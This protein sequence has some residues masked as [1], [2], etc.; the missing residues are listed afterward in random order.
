MSENAYLDQMRSEWRD[1]A[2][3]LAAWILKHLVNRTDVWGRYLPK[4]SRKTNAEKEGGFHGNAITA[5]FRD[6]RGKVFLGVSS[7]EKHFKAVDGGVLGIHSASSDGSSRWFAIDIDL[8]DDDD[9]SV[10]R[11]GNFVAAREWYS[12]LQQLG[13]DPLLFDSKWPRRIPSVGHIC[14]ADEFTKRPGIRRSARPG[15]SAARFGPIARAIPR[16][17]VSR[18]NGFESSGQLAAT[19]RTTSHASSLHPRLQR[20]SV[21]RSNLAG[22]A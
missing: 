12:A 20:S 5:P 3:E 14:A 2:P 6:E 13:L 11:E 15:L 16:C 8:H 19:P 10:T 22:G 1:R 17:A 18:K 21:G 9:L 4:R 7:L